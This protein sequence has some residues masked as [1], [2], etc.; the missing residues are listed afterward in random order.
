MFWLP[1]TNILVSG[2][3]DSKLKY[4]DVRKGDGCVMESTLPQRVFAMDANS[5]NIVVGMANRELAV[6]DVRSVA[7]PIRV[8]PC[9]V[10]Q[11]SAK[12]LAAIRGSWILTVDASFAR[13][14]AV[15]TLAADVAIAVTNVHKLYSHVH[16][17][18]RVRGGVAGGSVCAA[19]H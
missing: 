9:R 18:K 1:E 11:L 13:H 17:R 7:S 6:Y 4:W 19:V 5:K 10:W 2:G 14:V 8:R 12:P 15:V 3:W 16:G